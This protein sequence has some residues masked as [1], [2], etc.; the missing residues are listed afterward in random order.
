MSLAFAIIGAVVW[1]ALASYMLVRG[2]E[3]MAKSQERFN[4]LAPV[5]S[6]AL[7]VPARGDEPGQRRAV[8]VRR[9]VYAAVFC[10]LGVVFT[11]AAIVQAA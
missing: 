4:A 10:L 8:Q 11:L 9:W 5:W 7:V 6:R 2:E 1:F 3:Y